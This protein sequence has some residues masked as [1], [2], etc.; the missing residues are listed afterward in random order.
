MTDQPSTIPYHESE[1]TTLSI[2]KYSQESLAIMAGMIGSLNRGISKLSVALGS[3]REDIFYPFPELP[4][5][6]R[7]QIWQQ[8]IDA[9]PGRI[10]D[11]TSVIH[12]NQTGRE[13]RFVSHRACPRLAGVNREARA[14]IF[15]INTPLF[16]PR[17][18]HSFIAACLE[19]DT[20]LLSAG[21]STSTRHIRYIR[22]QNFLMKFVEA[23][24]E[25][26][27]REFRTLALEPEMNWQ[28]E[29]WSISR[30]RMCP[31]PTREPRHNTFLLRQLFQNIE[32]VVFVPLRK[33]SA[34]AYV[35]ELE[36]VGLESSTWST[37]VKRYARAAACHLPR[38]DL[39]FE[40]MQFDI[41]GGP[42]KFQWDPVRG[43]C[44]GDA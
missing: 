39:K 42:K 17:T 11:V 43:M 24:G 13:Y 33:G 1:P 36:F 29:R 27:C 34:N 4:T 21:F 32:K 38:E 19:K 10:I 6:I 25:G 31:W 26:R 8:A 2:T 28:W 22:R 30:W 37:G 20:I 9:L 23:L 5:E 7:L 12:R 40:F 18:K 44:A 41:V 35:G 16:L 3:K 14:A 15:K